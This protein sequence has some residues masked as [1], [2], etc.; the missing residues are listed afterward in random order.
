MMAKI[1]CM[2]IEQVPV[3]NPDSEEIP[4]FKEVQGSTPSWQILHIELPKE[5]RKT[6]VQ[7]R[8]ILFFII[9]TP[10]IFLV[11]IEKNVCFN[12]VICH[13]TKKT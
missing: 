7:H 11:I 12:Y 10:L 4:V 6:P 5:N 8:K 13:L 3:L 1:A 2:I 9:I